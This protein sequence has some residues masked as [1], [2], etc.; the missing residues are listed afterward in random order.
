[1]AT[2]IFLTKEIIGQQLPALNGAERRLLE[3]VLII[4]IVPDSAPVSSGSPSQFIALFFGNNAT[5]TQRLESRSSNEIPGRLSPTISATPVGVGLCLSRRFSRANNLV[6]D[7]HRGDGKH[8]VVHADEK[9]TAFM[10][11]ESVI[12][13]AIKIGFCETIPHPSLSSLRP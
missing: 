5:L 11:L 3:A 9:L 8:F 6:V 1:M 13:A 4:K 12:R 7:A 10:E 2:H